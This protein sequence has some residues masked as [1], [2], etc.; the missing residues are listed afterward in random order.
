MQL[1]T[2]HF[3]AFRTGG[4][5]YYICPWRR[6]SG[7]IGK[8]NVVNTVLASNDLFQLVVTRDDDYAIHIWKVGGGPGVFVRTLIDESYYKCIWFEGRNPRVSTVTWSLDGQ[9]IATRVY[10][11]SVYGSIVK[12]MRNVDIWNVRTGEQLTK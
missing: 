11:D 9:F 5:P 8:W 10:Y 3:V 6:L 1:Q 12:M 2:P 7:F 4:S